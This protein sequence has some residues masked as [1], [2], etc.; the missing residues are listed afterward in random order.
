[1]FFALQRN[2]VQGRFMTRGE[3]LAQETSGVEH[4]H[5]RIRR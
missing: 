3:A 2:V 4:T 5:E 1:M